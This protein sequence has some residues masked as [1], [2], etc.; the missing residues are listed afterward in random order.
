MTAIR[1]I[2]AVGALVVSLGVPAAAA[3]RSPWEPFRASPFDAAAGTRCSFELS[4]SILDDRERIRTLSTFPDG[5]PQQQQVK[6][7]LVVRYTNNTTGAHVDRDLTGTAL[8]TNGADG[9]LTLTLQ[10]GH[11]AVGL[12]PADS[13]GPSFLV[14]TGR[15]HSV[16]IDAAGER[17]LTLG[18]GRVENIC[19]TLGG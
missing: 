4:G 9:S 17:T 10:H 15:G 16:T 3:A 11:I 1:R 13:G 18:T 6:G 19:T 8:V 5:S 12:G 14:L 7:R 2:A